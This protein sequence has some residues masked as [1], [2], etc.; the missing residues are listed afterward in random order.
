MFGNNLNELEASENWSISEETELSLK[1]LSKINTNQINSGLIGTPF[2]GRS[3]SFV[4][5]MIVYQKFWLRHIESKDKTQHFVLYTYDAG[6]NLFGFI[7]KRH[8]EDVLAKINEG[9]LLYNF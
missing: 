1:D 5:D 6:D 7:M 9:D 3:L 2:A 4:F 8:S